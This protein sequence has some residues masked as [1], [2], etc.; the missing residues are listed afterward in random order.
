MLWSLA[1]RAT[2]GEMQDKTLNNWAV[3]RLHDISSEVFRLQQPAGR[4]SRLA[5]RPRDEVVAALV[6]VVQRE[7]RR[8]RLLGQGLLRTQIQVDVERAQRENEETER[9][10]A[11]AAAMRFRADEA[12]A[13]RAKSHAGLLALHAAACDTDVQPEGRKRRRE[14]SDGAGHGT[15]CSALA[16]IR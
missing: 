2:P 11:E 1:E 15:D 8:Q 13:R 5:G 6:D 16:L 4:M 10:E 12:A 14:L 3:K 7:A 9:L